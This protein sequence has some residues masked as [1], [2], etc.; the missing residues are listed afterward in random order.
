MDPPTSVVPSSAGVAIA[1]RNHDGG[2]AASTDASEVISQRKPDP[3]TFWL[4]GVPAY[5][6]G[7]NTAKGMPTLP[8]P[9]SQTPLLQAKFDVF[10]VGGAGVAALADADAPRLAVGSDPAISRTLSC[11]R[12]PTSPGRA[13]RPV[14][15]AGRMR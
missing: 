6:S 10:S 15:G 4:I 8:G 12:M 7:V 2:W 13:E 14:S 9:T 11:S 3:A 5:A 1:A